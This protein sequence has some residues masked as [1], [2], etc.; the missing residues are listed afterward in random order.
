MSTLDVIEGAARVV[1]DFNLEETCPDG[2][3]TELI[4]SLSTLY[5]RQITVIVVSDEAITLVI[6]KKAISTQISTD[7][8][9]AVSANT[10]TTAQVISDTDGC[11]Q[12]L[13]V[14]ATNGSGAA[15]TVSVW[16]AVRP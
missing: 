13:D 4:T 2:D 8:T 16:V 10:I 12:T 3:T 6:R 7:A 1:E 9:T 14:L 11:G 5:G 15:A